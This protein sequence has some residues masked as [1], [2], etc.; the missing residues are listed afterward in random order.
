[1]KSLIITEKPS[2]ARDIANVLGCKTKRDGYIEGESYVITWA[3]G[4][5]ITLF[6]P[7]DYSDTYKKWHYKSLPIIPET[8][9]IK[10]YPKT[11]SQLTIIKNLIKRE[12]V[13][14]LICATDSGREGELIFRYIYDYLKSKKP[15]E[16]LWISSMTDESI[17]KGFDTL[18][19]SSA[20]DNL[21]H[22]A[23]C[24]SEADWLVGINATR[25][26]TTLN[27][28]LLS[29]GRVQTPTLA[30]IVNRNHEIVAFIPQDYYEVVVDYGEFK[31]I[32]FNQKPSET[33][34]MDETEALAIKNKVFDRDGKVTKIEKKKKVEKPP[35]LYD[36]TEL[37]RDGNK[38]YGYS[39]QDV[40]TYAQNLYERYKLLT[41]PRTDSRYLSDDMKATVN[42]TMAH[43]NIPPY[44]KA[45]KSILAKGLKFSNRIID[46]SKVTDHHAV[47]PTNLKP[48]T[49]RVPKEE[50][51]IY[52]L[53]VKRFIA[54]FY[55]D[56]I[57]ET[58]SVF[59]NIEKEKFVSKGKVIIQKGWKSLYKADKDDKDQELPV[60]TKNDILHVIDS[61]LQKKQTSP[62]KPYTEATLLSAMENAGR[63]VE[64]EDLKEQL[65]EAGFG[66]P[67]TRASIIERLIH[68]K[69]IFRK[70]KGLF[71]TEK[72]IKLIQIVPDELKLAETT[73]KWEK[74]LT[75][76]NRGELEPEKFMSSINRFV[77]YIVREADKNKHSAKASIVPIGSK[78]VR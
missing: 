4:H 3:V 17:K 43:I 66:T 76:I 36:L 70:G 12:D 63:Y 24:R 32:W 20:Y 45:I 64:D 25:A 35:L 69:Y 68:V 22:S 31:G 38:M 7:E 33:K 18:K 30:L 15:F 57:Y 67:A 60:I 8:I 41:Y 73:G 34:I 39:A 42:E 14:S 53:V 6:E 40:L 23:K 48:N 71:P 46:N 19:P 62:P 74:G 55:P 47:I 65:K 56:F 54:V 59:V 78:A 16:R 1:M 51:T 5:L 11:K 37:Q 52:N 49:G 26:Y 9:K 27:N 10:P 72:G 77:S 21:Y 44:D 58:T 29:I 13:S 2:V 75:K 28:V 61:E 50:M